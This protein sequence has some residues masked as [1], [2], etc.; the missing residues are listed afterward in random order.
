MTVDTTVS[1]NKE[2]KVLLSDDDDANEDRLES[3]MDDGDDDDGKGDND[4]H[5]GA[6]QLLIRISRYLRSSSFM[7]LKN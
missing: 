2:D 5:N 1:T 6:T 4:A 7:P 3:K